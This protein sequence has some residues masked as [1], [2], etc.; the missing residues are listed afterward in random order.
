MTTEASYRVR[1]E[2][3]KLF[4]FLGLSFEKESFMKLV[5]ETFMGYLKNTHAMVRTV[6]VDLSK[7]LA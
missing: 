1:V 5:F 7:Q 2:V 3:F 6:G 4:G